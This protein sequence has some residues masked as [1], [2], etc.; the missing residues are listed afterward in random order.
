MTAATV[1]GAERLT[2][3]A[4]LGVGYDRVDVE[5]CTENGVLL[6]IAPEGVRR[7]MASSALAFILA[8]AHGLSLRDRLTRGG[9]WDE[10]RERMG[11][12]LAGRT[13]GVIGLGNIGAELLRLAAPFGMRRLA[14]DPYVTLERAREQGAELVSLEELLR[15]SDFVCV[16]CPLNPETHHLIDAERLGLMKPSAYL[17]NVARGPIV[18]QR[19]LAVALEGGLIA[20]AALDVFEEE[21]IDPADPIL[22]M[23]NVIVTPHAVGLTDEW[24][25]VTGRSACTA[26]LEVAAA[27][28][29]RDVVNPEVIGSPKLRQ[30]LER[31]TRG[32]TTR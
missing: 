5:A 18:D 24:A 17:V 8:L 10:A 6:T 29:P 4:R 9:R 2:L 11:I 12:G 27:R 16:M 3:L 14:A 21:P 32:V 20:G 19:A 1:V 13:L 7:P 26:A 31:R 28:V 23:E 15:D 22:G 25:L 30:K